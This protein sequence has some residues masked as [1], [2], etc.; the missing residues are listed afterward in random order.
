MYTRPSATAAVE[1]PGKLAVQRGCAGST[2]SGRP[3]SREAPLCS[4]PRQLSQ[5]ETA[6]G[7]ETERQIATE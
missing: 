3:V 2:L 1:A 7:V 6:A 5:P 4:G